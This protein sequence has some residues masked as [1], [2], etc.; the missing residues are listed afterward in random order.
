[1]TDEEDVFAWLQDEVK[2]TVDDRIRQW[3]EEF[4]YAERLWYPIDTGGKRIR[5][6]LVFL[7][8]EMV[9]VPQADALDIAAGVELL[10]NFTLV[11]DD[12]IDGDEY[13]RGE[14]TLWA[15]HGEGS[16][17]NLGDMMFAK[18]ILC[19][20]AETRDLALDTVI[21]VTNGEQMDIDFADRRDTT[22]EEYMTMVRR[23]T[24][25]LLELCVD[26]PLALA[27]SDLDLSG[28]TSLGPAFQIRDDLLDFQEGKGREQIGNDVRA[29]K[30]TL[31]VVHADDERVY[32][33]LD[34]PFDETTKEDVRTVMQI[35][36][37]EGSM[38]FAEQRMNDL[39]EEARGAITELPDSP[40]R[41]KLQALG[42]FITERDV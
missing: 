15:E 39:I 7:V 20:P 13:R 3:L 35:L 18:A 2:P 6:G 31:M 41:E 22:V 24:G 25:A 27:D 21:T 1:M 17:I 19:F 36:E 32:D 29:G 38:A 33:I 30:R 42:Q 14:P 34:K 5:P 8:S 28:F 23:K 10:H 12:I 26:A 37:A 40:Q 9:D 4:E 11:H 16:A